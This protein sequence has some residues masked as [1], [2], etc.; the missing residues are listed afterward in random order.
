M[1]GAGRVD[2]GDR[3]ALDDGRVMRACSGGQPHR[4]EDLLVARAAAE[5]A[6]QRLADLGV[7]SGAGCAR[8]R[9]WRGDDQPRRAEAALHRAGL[10]ERLLDRV[11]LVAR[12]PSP[13]T[14]T[15]SRPSACAGE[16]QAR[17]H[18]LAV[19]VDRARAALALLA[20]VLRA[21][22]GRG[23]RAARKQA[24]ALPD[25]VDLARLA[26][27]G[28]AS[29]ASLLLPAPSV[30]VRRA[31]HA[32]RVAAVGGAAADVVDRRARRAATSVAEARRAP[33]RRAAPRAVPR[34]SSSSTPATNASASARADRRRAGRADA[35]ARP[36]GARARAPARA[37]TPR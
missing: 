15:T 2:R 7:A 10:E 3:A 18:E 27:D 20:G 26:V 14:V 24:L 25:A 8:S 33:R 36:R 28:A 6:G 13:S 30:S 4:V 12:R 22:A 32:E 17:A 35:R 23:A 29:G 11:Q 16:H 9:S 19:E 21:R 1:L 34:P 31:E 5:V 37:S